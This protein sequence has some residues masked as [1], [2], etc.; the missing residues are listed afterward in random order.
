MRSTLSNEFIP[1]VSEYKSFRIKA[2]GVITRVLPV[3][4]Q[5]RSMAKVGLRR[6]SHSTYSEK[7]I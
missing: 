6:S 5:E 3:A 2:I 4:T 7:R 1:L